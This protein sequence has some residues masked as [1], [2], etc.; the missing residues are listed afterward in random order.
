MGAVGVGIADAL[1]NRQAAGLEQ[2]GGISYRRVEA[3][4][5]VDLEKFVGR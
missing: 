4:M 5:V 1:D 2:L 3:D